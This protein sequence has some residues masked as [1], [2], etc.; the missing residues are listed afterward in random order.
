MVTSFPHA[1]DILASHQGRPPYHADGHPLESLSRSQGL[2][3]PSSAAWRAVSVFSMVP[4][5][6]GYQHS[7][8]ETA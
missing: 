4:P 7:S 1:Q 6:Q 8:L 3:C 5:Q 2:I